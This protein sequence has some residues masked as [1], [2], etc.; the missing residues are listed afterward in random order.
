MTELESGD[1]SPGV[2]P[3][4]HAAPTGAPE[5]RIVPPGNDMPGR[6]LRA[7]GFDRER[8]TG[9]PPAPHLHGWTHV[10]W[11]AQERSPDLDVRIHPEKAAALAIE[12]GQRGRV[13]TAPGEIDAPAWIYAGI[14]PS[15]VFIPIGWGE[16][17]PWHRGRSGDFLSDKRQRDPLSD[18]TIL[19]T[20]PCRISKS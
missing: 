9:R 1:P 7:L 17:Q 16:R 18:Q 19:K 2:I 8:V 10:F 20:L 6:R 4:F 3:P 12:D 13:E 11:Q 5:A 15:A 14:R